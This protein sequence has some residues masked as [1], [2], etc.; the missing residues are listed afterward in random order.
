MRIVGLMRVKNEARWI[1]RAIRSL[2]TICDS[3]YVLDDHSTDG[4][5]EIAAG[6][7]HAVVWRS[8]FQGLDESRDKT[9]LYAQ[10]WQAEAPDW[11]VM[12]DGDEELID[13]DEVAG[14]CER[15]GAPSYAPRVLYLWDTDHQV[16][17]D[18]VYGRFRRPSVFRSSSP[19]LSFKATGANGHF[20]CSN[21]PQQLLA[22]CRP[23]EARILHYGYRDRED[24]LRKFAWYRSI[25]GANRAEDGYRHMVLGDL[26]EYPA[27]LRLTHGGPLTLE[28][29]RQ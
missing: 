1:D 15:R 18:G 12:I 11:V 10:M 4:T 26:P 2:L 19:A 28:D 17:V 3:V 6:F 25:D 23:T 21:V 7:R 24:R 29:W 22:A 16:R 20:H 27:D 13:P 8:P 14:L 9:W 5:A